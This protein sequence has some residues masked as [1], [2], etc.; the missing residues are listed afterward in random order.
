M[1]EPFENT[2]AIELADMDLRIGQTVQLITQGPKAS[3]HYT[4]LIGHVE[5]EFIMVR[6]PVEKGW[7]VPMEAGQ[8]LSVRVFCGVSLFEFDCRLETVLLHPRNYMLLSCPSHI[9]QTRLRSHE[10]AKCALP[11]QVVQAHGAPPSEGFQFQDISGSGAALLGPVALGEPGASLVL[12]L[13]FYL[14]AT[15]TQECLQLQAD[16]QSVQAVRNQAGQT[17]GYHHGVRFAQVEPRIL[18]L[19]YELLKPRAA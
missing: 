12:S 1:S 11:V 7:A 19:V 3:K 6:V 5:R 2:A 14:A 4:R 16:I 18:L 17:T 9:R 13:S 8:N 10:R 15:D